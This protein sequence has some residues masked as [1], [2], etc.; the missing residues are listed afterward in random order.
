[1]SKFHF[2]F[3][4]YH[5]SGAYCSRVGSSG[6]GTRAPFSAVTAAT[7]LPRCCYADGAGVCGKYGTRHQTQC[8][9]GAVTSAS[10]RFFRIIPCSPEL[11]GRRTGLCRRRFNQSFVCLKHTAN[12]LKKQSPIYN[13]DSLCISRFTPPALPGEWRPL[14]HPSFPS[15]GATIGRPPFPA[16]VPFPTRPPPFQTP[17]FLLQHFHTMQ[18]PPVFRRAALSINQEGC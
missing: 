4:L 6:F 9:P 13:M 1:M 14:H 17:P 18:K 8:S 12:P 7:S 15:V 10:S 5:P 11:S 2:V 16:P 3:P